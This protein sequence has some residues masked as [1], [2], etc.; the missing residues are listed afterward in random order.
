MTD[1]KNQDGVLIFF[2]AI[3]G[4]VTAASARYHQLPQFMLYRTADQRMTY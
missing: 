3:E 2:E 1:R 4:Q